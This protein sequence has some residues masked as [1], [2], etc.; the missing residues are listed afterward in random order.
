MENNGIKQM[1]NEYVGT[2]DDMWQEYKEY[3]KSIKTLCIQN[4]TYIR[5]H[6][7][8]NSLGVSVEPAS[9][10][11][12]DIYEMTIAYTKWIAQVSDAI[13]SLPINTVSFLC[14]A[15]G[16]T[17]EYAMSI[18]EKGI[19]FATNWLITKM[20]NIITNNKIV[21]WI[22]K[23]IKQITL[24]VQKCVLYGKLWMYKAMRNILNKAA[25]GK[26]TSALA[27][28]Y[29]AVITWIQTNIQIIE[30]V[31]LVITNLVNS[32]VGFTL[33]GGAMG[34][35]TTP[36]SILAGVLM[37]SPQL[38]M[39]P[40][41]MNQ[42]IFTNIADLLITPLE[43]T[44]RQALTAK[45]VSETASTASQI[46]TNSAIAVSTGVVVPVQVPNGEAFDLSMLKTLIANLLA[47]LA[48]PEAM[49]KYERVH[50]GNIGYLTW[51]LTSFQPAMKRCFGLPGY[52]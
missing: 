10:K 46:A 6:K 38:T 40:Q 35:F 11:L 5:K 45:K 13:I 50:L 8:K 44:V 3:I 23:T 15:L 31:L 52:P 7:I 48:M 43:E 9:H 19:D 2:L 1:T 32:L 16:E 37:P 51:M 39:K 29:A 21:K 25:N 14:R 34:F 20:Q 22:I 12:C 26:V 24:F 36:K 18:I 28:A 30:K 17:V 27:S 47:T 41:N 4:P 49:P 42:D 33:E